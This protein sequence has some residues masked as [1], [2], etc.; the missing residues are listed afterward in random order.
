M[1]GAR[2]KKEQLKTVK[3]E[4][5]IQDEK[6]KQ[7]YKRTI[8]CFIQIFIYFLFCLFILCVLHYLM[9]TFITP[10]AENIKLSMVNFVLGIL[11]SGVANLLMSQLFKDLKN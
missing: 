3:I 4:S 5:D 9:K 8:Y 6:F 7:G 11:A 10:N 1:T 2:E